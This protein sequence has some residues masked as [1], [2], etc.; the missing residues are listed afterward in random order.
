[1]E[2]KVDAALLSRLQ[3]R[4]KAACIERR[5]ES[6][7]LRVTAA[8]LRCAARRRDAMP[9][10][11]SE[12]QAEGLT[13]LAAASEPSD[14]EVSIDWVLKLQPSKARRRLFQYNFKFSRLSFLDC[15]FD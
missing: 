11:S 6:A 14:P 10:M 4:A 2:V 7:D 3:R 8:W 5:P 12:S 15:S 1:M 9:A 13:R